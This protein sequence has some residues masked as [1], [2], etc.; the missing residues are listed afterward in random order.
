MQKTIADFILE[1]P[2]DVIMLSIT[3]LAGKC[4]TSETTVL[5][6]L[7]KMDYDSYQVFRIN[8]AQEL[9]ERPSDTINEEISKNDPIDKIKRKV[10]A[11]TVTALN[12][13]E[14]SLSVEKL[15]QAVDMIRTAK[16]VLFFGVGASASI[17]MDAMHKFGNIGINVC[18]YPDPHLMN[19]ICTHTTPEELLIGISHTGE[20]NEVLNAVSIAKK[21]KTKI[22]GLTSY[23]SSSL[24]KLSDIYFLSSTNN[25]KYH[26]EAMASRILQLAIIDI[27]YI[28][29]F[30]QNEALYYDALTKS[31]F[32]VSL[33]KT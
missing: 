3:D 11:R 10:L 32:S 8:L 29:I 15:T 22:I 16:R 30:T 2:H 13:L 31:R 25:K 14:R 33:N 12:D 28:S 21:N 18:S 27:I 9:A 4:D 19:I 23:N 24:A 26:S 5:R 20:S 6:L 17:S 1:N 7:K